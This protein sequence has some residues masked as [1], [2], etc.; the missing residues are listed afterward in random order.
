MQKKKDMTREQLIDEAVEVIK[1]DFRLGEGT[2]L[3]ELLTFI[4]TEKLIGFLPDDEE[5]D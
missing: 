4:P 3:A 5:W 1:D 2:A